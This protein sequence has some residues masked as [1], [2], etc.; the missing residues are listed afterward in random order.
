MVV[1]QLDRPQSNLQAVIGAS[2]GIFQKVAANMQKI[3]RQ[4]QLQEAIQREIAA[5]RKVGK[6]FGKGGELSGFTAEIPA[7]AEQGFINLGGDQPTTGTR[8]VT[9]PS[10]QTGFNP[11]QVLGGAPTPTPTPAAPAL[12]PSGI[13][14]TPEGGFKPTKL[15][16]KKAGQ[17]V[18]L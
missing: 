10:A 11:A 6:T 12:A 8:A 13:A 9:V 18:A 2:T 15:T 4:K 17:T 3:E 16:A 7:P 5:G 1:I 14:P